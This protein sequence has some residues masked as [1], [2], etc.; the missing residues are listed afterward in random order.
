MAKNKNTELGTLDLYTWNWVGYGYNSCLASSRRQAI[1]KARK[2]GK[3]T[4]AGGMQV[5]LVPDL[6]TL[7][8]VTAAEMV[9]ID[10]SWASL[11][12]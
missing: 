7:R 9:A 6:K 10:R 5:T 2:M 4:V 3:P 1:S 12:D 8:K 11:F